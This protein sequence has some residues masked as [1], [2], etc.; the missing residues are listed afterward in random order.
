MTRAGRRWKLAGDEPQRYIFHA[1]LSTVDGRSRHGVLRA[2]APYRIPGHAL[3]GRVTFRAPVT[4]SRVAAQRKRLGRDVSVYTCAWTA[5][6]V[7]ERSA[8]VASSPLFAVVARSL[9][10]SP[11]MGLQG[12]FR[13]LPIR[14]G[15]RSLA[16]LGR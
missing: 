13:S 9:W 7:E 4:S 10:L 5:G 6:L 15:L 1:T 3:I 2:P 11:R 8:Y 14:K 16:G 12:T